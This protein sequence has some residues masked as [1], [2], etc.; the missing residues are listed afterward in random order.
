MG[1][2]LFKG[3]QGGL[4]APV[5]V[6]DFAGDEDLL[7]RQAAGPDGLADAGLVAVEIRGV[8]VPVA[9]AEGLYD[10][11][12]RGRFFG[13]EVGAEAGGGDGDTVG[14]GEVVRHGGGSFL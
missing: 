10:G 5:G 13:H 3:G 12:H 14:E 4:I 9:Q 8:D 1:H 11:V 2:G 6:P 7:P